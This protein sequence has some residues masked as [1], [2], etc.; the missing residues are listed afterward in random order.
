MKAG[1]ATVTQHCNKCQWT[2]HFQS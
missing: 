1:K 2:T